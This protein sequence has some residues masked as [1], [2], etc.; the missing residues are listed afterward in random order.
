MKTVLKSTLLTLTLI[1]LLSLGLT[2][3]GK[4]GPPVPPADDEPKKESPATPKE[5]GGPY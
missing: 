5:S 2:A 3:C 4:K 1:V